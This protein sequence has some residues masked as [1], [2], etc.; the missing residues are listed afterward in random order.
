MES[1]PSATLGAVIVFAAARVIDP[2]AWREL[3][4]QSKR[5]FAI[6][7]VTMIG[8]IVVGV[9]PALLVAIALSIF[10]A[11]SRSARPHDAVLGYSE[12]HDTWRDVSTHPRVKTLPGIVVYRLEDRLFFANSEYVKGRIAEA[13]AGATPPVHWFVFDAEAVASV[14]STGLAAL[15]QLVGDLARDQITFVIARAHTSFEDSIETSGLR[16]LEG[17]RRYVTIRAAI[18]ACTKGGAG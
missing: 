6:A 10:D 14:D 5:E 7:A 11:V 1:L 17:V 13:I 3:A 8:V 18:D 4:R 2:G 9:L 12:R 15:D 16:T